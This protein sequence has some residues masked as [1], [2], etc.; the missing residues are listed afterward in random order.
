MKTHLNILRVDFS[1]QVI[2]LI[3]NTSFLFF[4]PTSF[5][6]YLYFLIIIG[7]YQ[8][9]ISAPINLLRNV[10]SV[11]IYQFRKFHFF[12]SIIYLILLWVLSFYNFVDNWLYF[13][14]LIILPQ[15]IAYAYFYLTV[16]EYKAYSSFLNNRATNFA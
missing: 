10:V 14:L 8:F 6:F 5:I 15:I 3:L 12:G 2:L 4:L 9:I 1:I 7:F 13:S 11:E 16:R